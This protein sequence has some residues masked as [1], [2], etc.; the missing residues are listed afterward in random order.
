MG[1][2]NSGEQVRKALLRVAG[3][4]VGIGAGSMLVTA[5]G[6]DTAWSVAVI[7]AALFFGFYLQRINYALMAIG[8]TLT[9]S[10][11]YLQLDEFSDALLLLRLE[12]TALGAAVASA[13]AVLVLPLHTRRVLRVAFSS[14]VQ[15][16]RQTVDHATGHLLGRDGDTRSTLTADARAVDAA[17]QALIATAQ[18]VRRNLFGSLD[19]DTSGAM[20][21]ASASRYYCRDLVADVEA[22]RAPDAAARLDIKQAAATLCQSLDAIHSALTGP[23]DMPYTRSSALL[24]QAERRLEQSRRTAAQTQLAIRDLKLIDGAMAALAQAI[25]LA[26]TDDDAEAS[27]A[28]NPGDMPAHDRV[29]SP[30]GDAQ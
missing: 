9:V 20:R 28:H 15:A 5:V 18:P 12:E 3:T 1:A 6:G 7:L 29:I 25:G 11:L 16:I 27:R 26:L 22:A 30:D 10:Q 8:I 24:D 19:E 17:Y 13:V 21:L 14:H 4:L 2:N 23:A